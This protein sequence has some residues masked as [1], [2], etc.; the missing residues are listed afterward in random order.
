MKF[1]DDGLKLIELFEG[2]KLESYRDINGLWTVGIG[3]KSNS[4]HEGMRID[5]AEAEALLSADLSSTRQLVSHALGDIVLNDNQFTALCCLTFNIGYGN[6]RSST[7]LRQIRSGN[8][9]DA[10]NAFL[11]WNKFGVMV[12]EGLTRRRQRERDLFLKT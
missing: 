11:L 2:C 3:H 12:S 7:V 6:L 4:V 1:T 8:L 9:P 10:A 5:Q